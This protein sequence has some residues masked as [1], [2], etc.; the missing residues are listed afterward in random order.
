MHSHAIALGGYVTQAWPG[1]AIS[2]KAVVVLQYCSMRALL[3]VL[4]WICRVCH[5]G[6]TIIC[7]ASGSLVCNIGL[8]SD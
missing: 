4:H 7:K 8:S 6:G 1:G 5:P 2:G 3:G